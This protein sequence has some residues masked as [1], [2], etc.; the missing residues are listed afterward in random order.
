MKEIKAFIH[1]HRINSVTEALRNS[2]LC[3]INAG[4]GCHNITVSNVQRLFTSGKPGQQ[5]YSVQ[6]AEPVIAEAKLELICD[7]ELA[8]QLMELIVNAARPTLGWIFISEIQA[9]QKIG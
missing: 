3:D 1:P 2:G 7:D 5:H 9:A 4:T 6:L 8:E